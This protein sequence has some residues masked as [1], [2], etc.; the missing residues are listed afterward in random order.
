MVQILKVLQTKGYFKEPCLYT[1]I[2]IL[3]YNVQ[4]A[5]KGSPC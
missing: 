4:P 1:K 3:K 2:T 5:S